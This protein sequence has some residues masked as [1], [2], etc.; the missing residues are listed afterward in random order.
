MGRIDTAVNT[1]DISWRP[2][3]KSHLPI[4]LQAILPV[5]SGRAAQSVSINQVRS[6]ERARSRSVVAGKWGELYEDHELGVLLGCPAPFPTIATMRLNDNGVVMVNPRGYSKTRRL[7]EFLLR[8]YAPRGTGA[9][10][11]VSSGQQDGCGLA[12]STWS[13]LAAAKATFELL[14]IPPDYTLLADEMVKIEP[15]DAI[16]VQDGHM[17]LWD[18]NRGRRLSDEYASPPAGFVGAVPLHRR[19]LTA[20]V[21]RRRPIY[22]RRQ[23]RALDGALAALC[24]A[25]AKGDS[26]IL[27]EAATI[28]S[29]VND[30]YFPKPELPVLRSLH[31][32]GKI[33][34]YFVAHSGT[35]YGA[36]CEPGEITDIFHEF[37][38]RFGTDYRVVAWVNGPSHQDVS[39]LDQGPVFDAN[40]SEK[41]GNSWL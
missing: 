28:S 5:L 4:H 39:F 11:S 36:V 6:H 16:G 25:L 9:V 1:G 32:D 37:R 35:C 30:M 19:L 8:T 20:D 21:A 24:V 12:T 31:R 10:V 23:R 14:K 26:R 18:F 17:V 3:M 2:P 15:T 7:V 34:G 38:A 40:H 29:E 22:T 13:M 27:A 41:E 33:F